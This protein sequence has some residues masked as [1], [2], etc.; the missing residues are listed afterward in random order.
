MTKSLKISL[1]FIITI[2]LVFLGVLMTSDKAYAEDKTYEDK[3]GKWTYSVNDDNEVSINKYTQIT[4]FTEVVIPETING[5]KV[6][7][8]GDEAFKGSDV[9]KSITI[10]SGVTSIGVEAFAGCINLISL[11]IPDS[12]ASIGEF[13]FYKC[14]VLTSITILDGV[15]SI[16]DYAFAACVNLKKTTI[17]RSVTSIGES[18][19]ADDDSFEIYTYKSS[20]ADQYAQENNIT[21]VYIDDIEIE[22]DTAREVKFDNISEISIGTIAG[23]TFSVITTSYENMLVACNNLKYIVKSGLED[24][25][26]TIRDLPTEADE[27]GKW[28]FSVCISV[29]AV[30]YYENTAVIITFDDTD[31]SYVKSISVS[32]STENLILNEIKNVKVSYKSEINDDK[33]GTME[34]KWGFDYFTPNANLYQNNLAIASLVLSRSIE[35]GKTDVE[36]TL[37]KLDF[38]NVSVNNYESEDTGIGRISFALASREYT[39]HGNNRVLIAVVCRGTINWNDTRNDLASLYID[40]F[41]ISAS[42]V[43]KWV[44]QYINTYEFDK[45]YSKDNIK[46]LVTGHSLGGV[47]A[48]LL[49]HELE[50]NTSSENIYTYTFAAPCGTNNSVRLNNV[51][52]ILNEEDVVPHIP[53]KSIISQK[54]RHG[55][56][57]WFNR[58]DYEPYIYNRFRAITNNGN[59]RDTMKALNLDLVKKKLWAHSCD[60]YLAYLLTRSD[61]DELWTYKIRCA[62]VACPVD[63]EVYD[64]GGN[65][66]GRVVNNEIDQTLEQGVIIYVEGDIKYIYMIYEGDYTFKLT[67]SDSGTMTYSIQDVDVENGTIEEKEVYN[68]VSLEKGKEMV[69]EISTT[70]EN[71]DKEVDLYVTDKNGNNIIKIDIDGSETELSGEDII[72]DPTPTPTKVPTNDPTP[73]SL[74]TP[75]KEPANDSTVSPTTTP[76][77]SPTVKPNTKP[78]TS[79]TVVPTASPDSKTSKDNKTTFSI[80]NKKTIKKTA[81]IKVKDKDKIKNITL[82]G[83]TVKIKKN[84]TSITVKLKSYKKKLKKK[85]KWNTLKVTDNKGNITTIKFKTK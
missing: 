7:R 41:G 83:K 53:T 52:N 68:N 23:I 80:K 85:G 27:N 35:A 46:F 8:I 62:K 20:Y 55:K 9:L 59:L 25:G 48:N 4:D 13:A 38:N 11:T 50:E 75:T 28:A 82:N 45:K 12:V 78:T 71:N 44:N 39:Y 21:V 17:P 69:S 10:P 18:A 30:E 58:K 19:F 81:K 15:T 73:K 60:T 33:I 47:T 42:N 67:G 49:A 3:Y 1:R 84:K 63:V 43:H 72:P 26:M 5:M 74:A 77:V 61:A 40:S 6:T 36:S 54:P 76:T 37:K 22:D 64:S 29:K 57:I 31:K 79:P 70:P 24:Q 16:G 34:I 56:D 51:F 2:C 32:D 66:V 14:S 65:L